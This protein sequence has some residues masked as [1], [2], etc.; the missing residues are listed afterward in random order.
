MRLIRCCII[1]CSSHPLEVPESHRP[2]K[3]FLWFGFEAEAEEE[4]EEEEGGEAQAVATV[5]YVNFSTHG[6]TTGKQAD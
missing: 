4:E 5:L 2:R 1:R 6:L 3:G